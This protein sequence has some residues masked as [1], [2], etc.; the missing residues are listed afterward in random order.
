MAKKKEQH[1]LSVLT[2][3]DNQ[4]LFGDFFVNEKAKEVEYKLEE[5]NETSTATKID[6]FNSFEHKGIQYS[7]ASDAVLSG[8]YNYLT[9]MPNELAKKYSAIPLM[10]LLSN[11]NPAPY[12]QRFSSN[13]LSEEEKRYRLIDINEWVNVDMF[14]IGSEHYELQHKLLC[15]GVMFNKSN[16]EHYFLKEFK[17][18]IHKLIKSIYNH[19]NKIELDIII[20]EMDQNSFSD[21]LY[22]HGFQDKEVKKHISTWKKEIGR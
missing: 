21:F 6:M 5:L 13:K 10:K 22:E 18:G 11:P 2:V 14:M 1:E 4:D 7:S 17:T 16:N 19:L 8:D 20:S 3:E 9:N 15:V 12:R